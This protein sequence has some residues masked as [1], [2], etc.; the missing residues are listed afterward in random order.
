M[1]RPSEGI[2]P[3][4][5][6]CCNRPKPLQMNASIPPVA[7]FGSAEQQTSMQQRGIKNDLGK[8]AI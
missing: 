3:D 8:E 1:G 4:L 7:R 5:T 2:F 6:A